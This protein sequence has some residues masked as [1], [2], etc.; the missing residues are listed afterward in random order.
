MNPFCR[1][2]YPGSYVASPWDFSKD[3]AARVHFI[4]F[5]R[6]QYIQTTRLAVD[7][8]VLDGGDRAEAQRRAEGCQLRFF[9]F[10]D[11]LEQDPRTSTRF[12][13]SCYRPSPAW[14]GYRFGWSVR[15]RGSR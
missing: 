10:L 4:G 7:Q 2:K 11:S 9:G 3:G 13:R 5:F 1:L 14:R 12:G 6:E 8:A 15:A